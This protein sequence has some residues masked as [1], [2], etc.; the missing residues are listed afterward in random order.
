MV[1]AYTNLLQIWALIWQETVLWMMRFTR[2]ARGLCLPVEIIRRYYKRKETMDALITS[3]L[4]AS[5][6]FFTDMLK[7]LAGMYQACECHRAIQE[8]YKI[9]LLLKQAHASLWMQ[10]CSYCPGKRERNRSSVFGAEDEA[11]HR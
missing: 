9:E 10:G 2:L 3:D 8:V 4:G 5:S 11:H 7:E 1:S 6:A